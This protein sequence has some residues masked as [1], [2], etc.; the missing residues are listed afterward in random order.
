MLYNWIKRLV[1]DESIL[2]DDY[3]NLIDDYSNLID[4]Y[5]NIPSLWELQWWGAEELIYFV[6]IHCLQ[7][8][9]DDWLNE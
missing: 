7:I 2:I 3:S 9:F 8:K 6:N 4:D 1:P 5:A